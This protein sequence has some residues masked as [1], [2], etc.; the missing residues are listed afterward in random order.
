MK[1]A[2]GNPRGR[3]P[4][5]REHKYLEVTQASVTLEDWQLIIEKAVEQAVAGDSVARKFL[6]EYVLGQPAQ[7]HEYLVS[8]QRDFTIR[9]VFEDRDAP[10]LGEGDVIDGEVV[11]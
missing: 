8:E 1:G 5:E 11:E 7:V 2:T 9:V 6:A 3:L 10:L 4:R